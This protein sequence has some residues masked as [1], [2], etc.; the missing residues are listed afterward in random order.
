MLKQTRTL[1]FRI[2]AST[3]TQSE[4]VQVRVE[5]ILTLLQTGQKH[6]H[7]QTSLTE[8]LAVSEAVAS[9]KYQKLAL[10]C[11]REG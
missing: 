11:D 10:Y 1:S 9:G 5:S 3:S 2:S 7:H 6:Y 4:T 8:P